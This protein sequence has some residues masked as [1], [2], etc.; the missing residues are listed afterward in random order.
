MLVRM[1][2]LVGLLAPHLLGVILPV[3]GACA[4]SGSL[5][6]LFFFRAR[7]SLVGHDLMPDLKSPL[8]LQSVAWLALLI[9]GLNICIV[10]AT[11]WA[12]DT[13]LLAFAALAGLADVDATILNVTRLS[14]PPAGVAIAAI[15]LAALANMISKSVLAFLAGTVKFGVLFAA[16]SLVLVLAG[17][18]VYALVSH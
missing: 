9:C 13:A 7:G 8:D 10:V 6:A 11:R 12:G 17:A 1:I 16:S 3:L 15:L 5:G 4:A 2:L 18:G 14:Q